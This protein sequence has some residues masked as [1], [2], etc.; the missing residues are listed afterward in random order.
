LVKKGTKFVWT[1][2]AERAFL[3]LKLRLVTQPIL[4]HQ[5]FSKPFSLAVD[6]SDVAIGAVLFQV[7]DGIE[8]PLCCFSKKLD[9]HQKRYSIV[10]KE[11]LGLILSVRAFSVYFGSA[12][13]RVFT[14][15]SP[16]QFLQ[17]MSTHN[18]KFL[19]WSLELDQYNL[20]VRHRPGKDNIFPDLSSR[21]AH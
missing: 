9:C 12:P 10:E 14:D 5:D 16:L 18:Q 19:R 7:V 2:E 11:A 8:H 15:N 20:D 3:D 13:V 17:R 1:V 4:R 21:P 6:A